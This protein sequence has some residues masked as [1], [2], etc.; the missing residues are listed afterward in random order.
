MTPEIQKPESSHA[1]AP[2][3]SPT[4]PPAVSARTANP[5]RHTAAGI[6]TT[7]HSVTD[8]DGSQVQHDAGTRLGRTDQHGSLGRQLER[9]RCVCDGSVHQRSDAHVTYAAAAGEPCRDVARLGEFENA[10]EAL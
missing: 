8:L 1:S 4:A 6:V 9:L 7:R 10:V 2:T 3:H 5:P